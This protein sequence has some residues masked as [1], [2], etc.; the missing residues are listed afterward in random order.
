MDLDAECKAMEDLSEEKRTHLGDCRSRELF[1]R[2]CLG[3]PAWFLE[4]LTVLEVEDEAGAS[5][6][7]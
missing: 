4:E 3:F 5:G 6:G 7:E 1:L 2:G